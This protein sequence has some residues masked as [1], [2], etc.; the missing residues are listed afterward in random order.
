MKS[1]NRI[2]F[3]ALLMCICGSCKKHYGVNFPQN[4]YPS[5]KV[6]FNLYTDKDFTNDDHQ[7]TFKMFI[8]KSVGEVLWDTILPSMQIKAIPDPAHKWVFEKT[9]QGYE[10]ATLKVGFNYAIENIGV[11]WFIETAEPGQLVKIVDYN[12]Q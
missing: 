10:A 2:F 12:F 1:L 6:V 9:I 5:R 8:Q 7:I 4:L 11:S 3:S